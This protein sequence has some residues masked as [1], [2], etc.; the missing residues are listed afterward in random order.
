MRKKA[1]VASNVLEDQRLAGLRHQIAIIVVFVAKTC[2][3]IKQNNPSCPQHRGE[4]SA[5]HRFR[6]RQIVRVGNV[7][8]YD[9][10]RA[11]RRMCLTTRQAEGRSVA[12]LPKSIDQVQ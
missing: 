7:M 2:N 10:M 6:P 4:V 1:R 3:F 9:L 5:R 8:P 11:L 12:R